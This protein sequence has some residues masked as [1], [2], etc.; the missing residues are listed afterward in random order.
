MC[1][2]EK[3]S[4]R[5][6]SAMIMPEETVSLYNVGPEA[7]STLVSSVMTAQYALEPWL[8]QLHYI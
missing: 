5:E 6:I 4:L 1:V 8:L 3:Y 7:E 2:I